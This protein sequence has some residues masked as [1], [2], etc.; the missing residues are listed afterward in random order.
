VAIL[1][2]RS[3]SPTTLGCRR[4]PPHKAIDTSVHSTAICISGC[5][6]AS[7]TV[8]QTRC[9]RPPS[10]LVQSKREGFGRPHVYREA[11]G[12]ADIVTGS[13]FSFL[14]SSDLREVCICSSPHAHFGIDCEQGVRESLA[15][16]F[17]VRQRRRSPCS[18]WTSRGSPS[19]ARSCVQCEIL[20]VSLRLERGYF[21]CS[22]VFLTCLIPV[23]RLWPSWRLDRFL[24]RYSDD[25]LLNACHIFVSNCVQ[26]LSN[27]MYDSIFWERAP[28]LCDIYTDRLTMR[29]GA[30]SRTISN[31]DDDAEH[32]SA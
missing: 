13:I 22:F 4:Q 7:N 27:T 28:F 14:L 26:Y 9:T 16:L 20:Q 2:R 25:V 32:V 11:M 30:S 8:S 10:D 15:A 1:P 21:V 12:V 24:R 3:S 19:H 18:P 5:L 17:S 31:V 29:S 23:D 6:C